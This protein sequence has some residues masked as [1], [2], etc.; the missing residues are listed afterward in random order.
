MNSLAQCWSNNVTAT[1][2][3]EDSSLPSTTNFCT[4]PRRPRSSVCS[5]HTVIFEKGNG[6]KGLGFTIVG[7]RDS[8]RGALGI[9]VKSIL[10][11]GQAAEDGRLRAGTLNNKKGLLLT[12]VVGK[13]ILKWILLCCAGDELLAVN[14]EVCHDL[15]H[16]EAVAIFKKI[17]C[18]PVVLH[19]CRRIRTKDSWVSVPHLYQVPIKL[20]LQW[21]AR[22]KLLDLQR[23]VVFWDV[24][25]CSF[26]GCYN[27]FEEQHCF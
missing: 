9:F 11:G 23:V 15:T 18:G 24:M 2:G 14:G 6:K 27:H 8:P 17:K 10:P 12:D 20:Y 19:I 13:I 21:H 5:F 16:S 4:L 3:K 22:N 25:L 26:L 7:G 1:A